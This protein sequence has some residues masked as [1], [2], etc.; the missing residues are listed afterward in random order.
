M[1]PSPPITVQLLDV[2]LLDKGTIFP[3]QNHHATTQDGSTIVMNILDEFR[4]ENRL[5]AR[6]FIVKATETALQKR[7][8]V[9]YCAK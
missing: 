6:I 5:H 1:V 2:P 4:Q 3:N 9:R 8:L 7:N